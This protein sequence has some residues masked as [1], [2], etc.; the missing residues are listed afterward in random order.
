MLFAKKSE[1]NDKNNRKKKNK[2]KYQH[3]LRVHLRAFKRRFITWTPTF[4]IQYNQSVSVRIAHFK[5]PAKNHPSL[6]FN[7]E[8]IAMNEK[9]PNIRHNTS[10]CTVIKCQSRKRETQKKQSRAQQIESK[11]LSFFS[12]L[13]LMLYY[14][15]DEGRERE[16]VCANDLNI[17]ST[18]ARSF[19]CTFEFDRYM[20]CVYFVR[21]EGFFSV[22]VF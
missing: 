9:R 16:S 19:Q 7:D 15:T 13:K 20:L 11:T 4:T 5:P 3:K 6:T 18:P 8:S 10:V 21:F 14:M 1:R 12:S 2:H 17:F 22:F